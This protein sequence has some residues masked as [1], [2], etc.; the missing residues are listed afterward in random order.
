MIFGRFPEEVEGGG[1][2]QQRPDR[3]SPERSGGQ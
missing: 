2:A 1:N 3:R